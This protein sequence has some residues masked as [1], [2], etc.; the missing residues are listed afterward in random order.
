[1]LCR[2]GGFAFTEGFR[3]VD[4]FDIVESYLDAMASP[5]LV[6]DSEERTMERNDILPN[7]EKKKGKRKKGKEDDVSR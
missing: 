2:F 1:V 3:G 4:L 7:W 5:V 6:L